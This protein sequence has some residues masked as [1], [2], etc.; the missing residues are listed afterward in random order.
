MLHG[1]TVFPLLMSGNSIGIFFGN[2]AT[3]TAIIDKFYLCFSV[4]DNALLHASRNSPKD[5]IEEC[6]HFALSHTR[7]YLAE[8]YDE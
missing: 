6:I 4:M 5:K 3:V 7:L 2:M 8:L 1:K